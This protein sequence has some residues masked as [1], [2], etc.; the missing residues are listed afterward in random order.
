MNE[1]L[2]HPVPSRGRW[3]IFVIGNHLLVR[4][5]L[6][7][8]ISRQPD[9]LVCGQAS[10]SATAIAAMMRE[11]ADA[12]V[13]DIA[14]PGKSGL[15]LIKKLRALSPSPRVLVLSL[16]DEEFYAERVLR[17]GAMGYVM[18]QETTDQVSWLFAKSS[19]GISI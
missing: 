4:E 2:F 13:V 5:S 1:T 10:D 7:T 6:A 18:K 11:P 14:L 15:E 12:V 3:R 16:H 19:Q 17:A 9:L 8:L